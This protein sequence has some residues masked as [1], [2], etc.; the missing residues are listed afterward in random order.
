MPRSRYRELD[1]RCPHFMTAAINNWL[2]IFTRPE[3]VNIVLDSWRFLQKTSGLEIFGYGILENN[4]HLVTRSENLSGDMQRFKAY[5]AREILAWLRAQRVA[6]LLRLLESSKRRRKKESVYQVW[7]EGGHS[8]MIKGE[9]VLTLNCLYTYSKDSLRSW[10]GPSRTDRSNLNIFTITRSNAATLTSLSIGVQ[11]QGLYWTARFDRD[12]PDLVEKGKPE[13]FQSWFPS[14]SLGTKKG[15]L[16]CRKH[17]D[18]LDTLYLVLFSLLKLLC[19][20][21]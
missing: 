7:E 12:L 6:R 11:R 4:P 20:C 13:L 10:R 15:G 5:T 19:T 8:R 1:R 18:F 9:P 21:G 16:K 17:A 14:S 2:P 3:T